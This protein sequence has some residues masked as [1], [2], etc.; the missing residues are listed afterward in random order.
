MGNEGDESSLAGA[1]ISL[2]RSL[3]LEAVAEGVETDEQARILAAL[4]CDFAQGFYFS[5]PVEAADME[6][7]LNPAAVST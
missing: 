1:I 3:R 5:H 2:A 6:Q 4:G 7:L